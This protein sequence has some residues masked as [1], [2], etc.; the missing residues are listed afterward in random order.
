MIGIDATEYPRPTLV[1]SKEEIVPA[2]D[3]TAVN[4][5]DTGCSL[6]ITNAPISTEEIL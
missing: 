3:T 4:A 6:G 1:T 2:A 5:A